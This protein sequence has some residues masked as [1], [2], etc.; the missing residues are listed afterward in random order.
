MS[1]VLSYP[2]RGHWGKASWHGNASGHLYVDLFKMLM[3]RVFVDPMVGSRT[4]VQVAEEMGIEA[5][6]LD[7]HSGFN[8]LRDRIIDTVKKEA[9]LI[10]SHPPYGGLM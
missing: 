9:D 8:I 4:S 10:V 1:N 3:P 5:Y 7:L 6:G 2:E